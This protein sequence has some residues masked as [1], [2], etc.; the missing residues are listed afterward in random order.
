MNA[1]PPKKQYSISN[2][3]TANE[4]RTWLRQLRAIREFMNVKL[5]RKLDAR[6]MERQTRRGL[7]MPATTTL[8][9]STHLIL[10]IMSHRI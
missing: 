1:K 4:R 2:D 5:V 7:R 8:V 3:W 6:T 9:S 10:Y